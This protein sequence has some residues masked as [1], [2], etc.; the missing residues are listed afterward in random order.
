MKTNIF[1]FEGPDGVG[2]TTIIKGVQRKLA[3]GGYKCM[4]LSFPG[5]QKGTLGKLVYKIH[6]MPGK[7]KHLS[8]T[9]L[10][11]LHVAAHI[12][13][14]E[15]CILPNISKRIILLDRWW[16]SIYCYGKLY[17]VNGKALGAMIKLEN[18]YWKYIKPR[19]IF[20]IK[21]NRSFKKGKVDKEWCVLKKHYEEIIAN[22]KKEK[23]IYVV[24][25]IEHKLNGTTEEICN[26]IKNETNH[27]K[28]AQI[29]NY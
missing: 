16:W 24:N 6:H 15:N 3:K 4:Y 23:N 8:Q 13:S 29:K 18:M 1:I 22:K 25:N 20:Y 9:S 5:N 21:A 17:R 14:I 27:N 7:F 26:I 19:K 12:D 10:Q 2:K 28:I 11:L